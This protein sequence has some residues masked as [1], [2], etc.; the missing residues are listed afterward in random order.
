MDVYLT[1]E[2]LEREKNLFAPREKQYKTLEG[3][4]CDIRAFTEQITKG[5]DIPEPPPSSC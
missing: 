3:K 4:A 5:Y 1:K 2:E